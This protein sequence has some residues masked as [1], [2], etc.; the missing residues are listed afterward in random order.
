ML[1]SWVRPCWTH[2]PVQ[3][4]PLQITPVCAHVVHTL[5][6]IHVDLM[7]LLVPAASLMSNLA[8]QTKAATGQPRDNLDPIA[9]LH[10]QDYH[11]SSPGYIYIS[12]TNCF[13]FL[14]VPF[15]LY[16]SRCWR[17]NSRNLC[18]EKIRSDL[19]LTFYFRS[20]YVHDTS[21]ALRL[22]GQP[23]WDSI[24]VHLLGRFE[25]SS[26]LE[27]RKWSDQCILH[28]SR[29]VGVRLWPFKCVSVFG[30]LTCN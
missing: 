26:Q 6:I 2:D 29:L 11:Q 13:R 30:S 3:P 17:G 8:W 9:L 19:S 25:W 22:P 18:E 21:H 20:P 7:E 4:W 15:R 28:I 16:E 23:G 14:K 24:V 10:N 27:Q 5:F 1:N 12:E